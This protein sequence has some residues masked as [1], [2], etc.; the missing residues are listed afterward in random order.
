MKQLVRRT[1]VLLIQIGKALPFLIC[2]LVL[3]SYTESL[4]SLLTEDYVVYDDE[5]ILRKPISWFLGNYFEYNMQTIIILIITSFAVNTCFTN[6]VACLY[7]CINLYEKEWFSTHDYEN[8][9][10]AYVMLINIDVSL[11][12]VYKGFK[13]IKF[14]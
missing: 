12:I 14:C 6:K 10:Y 8:D 13:R 7:L 9:V 3:I 5:V 11:I 4:F 1:R 2:F